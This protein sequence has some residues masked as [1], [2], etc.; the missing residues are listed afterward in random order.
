MAATW[1]ARS[2]DLE[3]WEVVVTYVNVNGMA[4]WQEVSG[5]GFPVVLLNG[6][7][8]EASSWSAQTPALARAGYRVH[9]PERRAHAHTPTSR[10]P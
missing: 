10:I 6:A 2:R 3:T 7:P 8:A 9:V 1:K 4:T 5:E